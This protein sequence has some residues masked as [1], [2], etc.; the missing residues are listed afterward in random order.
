MAAPNMQECRFQQQYITANGIALG[1]QISRHSTSK[2]AAAAA[3]RLFQQH[4]A[5]ADG[6]VS[7]SELGAAVK[8]SH[9]RGAHATELIQNAEATVKMCNVRSTWKLPR[10]DAHS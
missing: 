9:G 2:A 8:L 10:S 3:E 1:K 7:E 4:D 6:A 5:N